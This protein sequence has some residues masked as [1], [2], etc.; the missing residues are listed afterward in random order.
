VSESDQASSE[1]PDAVLLLVSAN[2]ATPTIN[3]H[4][5]LVAPVA[6]KTVAEK[7]LLPNELQSQW[8]VNAQ[9]GSLTLCVQS[10]H[11]VAS[12]ATTFRCLLPRRGPLEECLRAPKEGARGGG[13]GAVSQGRA[14]AP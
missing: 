6:G 1:G 7:V 8:S 14:S 11:S 3:A 4:D 9:Q 10:L 12:R 2:T 5:Y 13:V